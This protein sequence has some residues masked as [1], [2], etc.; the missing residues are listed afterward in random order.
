[1]SQFKMR[2]LRSA[3]L[4]HEECLEDPHSSL[5]IEHRND[6]PAPADLKA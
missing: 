4:T 6:W 3:K 2:T 1:M 5:C